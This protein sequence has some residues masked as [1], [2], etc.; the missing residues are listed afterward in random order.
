MFGS[1][2]SVVHFNQLDH[3]FVVLSSSTCHLF[4][5]LGSTQTCLSCEKTYRGE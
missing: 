5:L 3:S 4:C 2:Q 1:E